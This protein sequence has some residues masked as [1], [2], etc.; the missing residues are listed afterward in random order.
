MSDK[1]DLNKIFLEIEEDERQIQTE[2]KEVSQKDIK[3]LLQ[4]MQIKHKHTHD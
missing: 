4:N 1:Y 3:Y 2:N